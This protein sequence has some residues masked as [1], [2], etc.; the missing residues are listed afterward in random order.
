[1]KKSREILFTELCQHMG[2]R[3]N[4]VKKKWKKMNEDDKWVLVKGFVLEWGVNFHP[5]SA[6]SVKE[7]VDEYLV[8][9]NTSPSDSSSGP[10][11]FPNLKKIMGFSQNK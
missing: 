11:L 7:L 3:D 5:L 4:E 2:M 1:M 8:E 10:M 9:D 6:K